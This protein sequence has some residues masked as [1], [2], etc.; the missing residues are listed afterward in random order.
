[1]KGNPR[2]PAE[3]HVG[4]VPASVGSGILEGEKYQLEH[5]PRPPE[6]DMEEKTRMKKEDRKETQDREDL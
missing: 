5:T 2:L 4:S 6:T 1:M 3:Q